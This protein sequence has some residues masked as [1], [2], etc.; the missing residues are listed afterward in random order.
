M[1]SI[2]LCSYG[3][4]FLLIQALI[5]IIFLC[6]Y[7]LFSFEWR[8]WSFI[9][10]AVRSSR[11]KGDLKSYSCKIVCH[12]SYYA[13]HTKAARE[14]YKLAV[15]VAACVNGSNSSSCRELW[16]VF[17]PRTWPHAVCMCPNCVRIR[18]HI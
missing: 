14:L 8:T 17:K 16:R 3:I 4:I 6:E 1:Y 18:C 13:I 11:D 10:P 12:P 2:K 9:R 5:T 15:V 7:L